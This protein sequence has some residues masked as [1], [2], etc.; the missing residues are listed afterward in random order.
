MTIGNAKPGD[1]LTSVHKT[2]RERHYSS[3]TER[4]YVS[5]TTIREPLRE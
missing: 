3:L 1:L 5:P 2:L 4:A